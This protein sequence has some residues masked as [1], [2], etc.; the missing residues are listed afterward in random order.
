M[1][2]K[3]EKKK[4]NFWLSLAT[5]IVD[6]RKAI[7]ILFVVAIIYSVLS[8]NKVE[9]N[10]DITSYLPLES[11]TRRG[12]TVMEDE[13]VTYGSARVMVSNITWSEADGLVERIE[14]VEGVKAVTFDNTKDHYI[15]ANALFDVT[16]DGEDEDSVS[17][18]AIKGIKQELSDYDIYVSTTIGSVEESAEMLNREMGV[19]LVLAVVII[20]GVLLLSTKAYLEIPVLLI[21]FGVAAILNM[22]TNYWLGEISFVTN[23]IAVVLQ[24]ALAID[25]AII[26]CDRFMEEHETLESED[27]AKVALSKAIPEI[28]ASSLTTISGMVALM[29]MQFKLGYDMGIVL[30]KAILFSLISVFFLM[31]GILLIFAKG[32]D[33]THHKCYVPKI[34]FLGKIAAK[35]KYIIP[36]IFI[37]VL[38][39]AFIAQSNCKYVFDVNS[40]ESAKKSDSKIAQEKIESVFGASNQLVVIVPSG[41]Y[42]K[43]GRVLKR[44]EELPYVTSALGLANQEISDDYTLTDKISPRQFAEMTDLDVEIV[45][46]LYSAYAYNEEQYGPVI[47]GIDDYEVPIIDMFL[48][49]YDQYQ[50]GYVNLDDDMDEMLTTLYDTLHDA[51]LQ[52]Q[53]ENYSRFVLSI[54]K[55]GEGEETYAAMDE[56][57][58]IGEQVY[59]KGNVILAGN[60]TSA[61]DLESTFSTDNTIINVMTAL[62]VMIILFFTFQ[63]A[64]LPV[65]LVMTIEGSIWINFTIPAIQGQTVYFIAYLIVSAIQMGATIDYAIVISSRYMQLKTEMPIE[66]A[67]VEAL[68]QSFPTIFT[69]GSIMTSAGF[70]IGNISTDATVSA[71]GTT[72]GRGTLT[73]IVLVLCVLPQVLLLGDWIIEKTAFTMNLAREQ[74][75]VAGRVR[76]T[77]HVRGYVQGEI[78]ADVQGVFHGQMKVAVD[79]VIPGRQGQVTHVDEPAIEQKEGKEIIDVTEKGGTQA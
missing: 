14:N 37:I 53:G 59:G 5:F 77:G 28:S 1:E 79:T 74:K 52:L 35:T 15:G 63:S 54:D 57:R 30:V 58:G 44:L 72:L 24:L 67:I 27:A 9:V 49:L 61:H 68:N 3:Q 21:T 62:F 50:Q 41:D 69:S 4:G 60:S 38:V 71:M 11:E 16:V 18:S 34:T 2:E 65:L 45:Q 56:I 51:Q 17:I 39:F 64:G 33:R 19:I 42:D 29:L 47:T 12:L 66:K 48:F 25:Y 78:D 75:D 70:L 20:I 43:E 46:V 7:E 76:I 55:P 31:P 40:V 10:Q 26:L 23:S 36:P 6:K 22:G 32:I 73:S 13:F 8:V